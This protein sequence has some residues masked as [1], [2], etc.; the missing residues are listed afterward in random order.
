MGQGPDDHINQMKLIESVP[1][2]VKRDIDK[3]LRSTLCL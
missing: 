1:E 3:S 2:K